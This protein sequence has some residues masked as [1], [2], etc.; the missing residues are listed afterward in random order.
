M[1]GIKTLNYFVN[2]AIYGRGNN[3]SDLPNDKLTHILY[4][5]ANIRENGEVF[6][7]DNWAD[8]DKHYPGDQW[9]EPGTN[10]YGCVKQLG[11]LKKH[12]RNSDP[13]R[14]KFAET[15]TQLILDWRFDGLD[16]DWEYPKNDDEANNLSLLLKKFTL[17]MAAAAAGQNRGFLTIAGPAGRENYT[18]FKFSHLTPHLDFYNLMAYDYS[19]AWSTAAGH[20]A[21][22]EEPTST[23]KN[24][25]YSISEALDYYIN[26]SKVPL[27]KIILGMPL[28]GR[29]FTNTDSPGHPFE[30]IGQGHWEQGIWDYKDLPFTGASEHLDKQAGAS[31]RFN[32]T[33]RMIIS[34]DTQEMGEIKAE[35]I[36]QHQLGG[37]MW[38]GSSGDKGGKAPR[39]S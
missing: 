34:Y 10:I 5:F 20:W 3:L 35:Y 25:P 30:G 11:L 1:S 38:W 9:D 8:I 26:K 39:K 14:T 19:G 6:R 22:L 15:A 12:N 31:W 36:L 2:W 4:T 27:P 32:P 33:D 29:G 18:K 17:D 21:N 7:T 24:T 13:G 23:P 28:Y 37:A 16:V